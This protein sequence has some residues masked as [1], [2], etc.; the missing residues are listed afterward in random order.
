MTHLSVWK[1]I[2]PGMTEMEVSN[3]MYSF[4][5]FYGN[6][7]IPYENIVCS[8]KNGATLHYVPSNMFKI[9]DG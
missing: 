9:K 5:K 4:K 1:Y 2:K 6:S 8:G 7:T 3:Y